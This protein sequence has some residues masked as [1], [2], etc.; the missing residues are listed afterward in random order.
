MGMAANTQAI[1][2]P[3]QASSG[4]GSGNSTSFGG[5]GNG[6]GSQGPLAFL[7]KALER[8]PQRPSQATGDS[9]VNAQARANAD[10][11]PK[12]GPQEPIR[13]GPDLPAVEMPDPLPTSPF[14][15]RLSEMT[16]D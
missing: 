12:E 13:L 7:A 15:L 5:S 8:G 6:S 16:A 14:L 11:L 1:A 10:A 3:Q 4:G 9:I 2:A